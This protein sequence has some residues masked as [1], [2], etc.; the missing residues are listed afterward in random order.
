[1]IA[2]VLTTARLVL[3]A[4]FAVGV[5]YVAR[6]PEVTTLAAILLSA[7]AII[8][9]FTDMFDGMVARRTGTSSKLGGIYDPLADSLARLAIYFAM[10]MVGWISMAVP[11]VMTGRDIIVAYTRIIHAATGGRTGARIS[12]KLKAIVQGGG[13]P[14]VV[15]M[16]WLYCHGGDSAAFGF[17]RPVTPEVVGVLRT[18]GAGILLVVTVWSL[19][20]YLFGA[21]AGMRKMAKM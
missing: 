8:E 14:V 17:L 2:H 16:A 15:G 10:A 21:L 7:L 20:D 19:I 5:A 18:V 6:R 1:M 9:E 12:G 3:A 13:I 4:G 11:L